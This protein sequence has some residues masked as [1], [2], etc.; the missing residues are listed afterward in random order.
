MGRAGDFAVDSLN[1]NIPVFR[2]FLFKKQYKN[3][4]KP[5]YKKIKILN[6]KGCLN[7]HTGSYLF[8]ILNPC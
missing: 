7:I 6:K 5:L 8:M 4:S 3:K 2:V 1:D